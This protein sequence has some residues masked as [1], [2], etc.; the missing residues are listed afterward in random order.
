MQLVTVGCVGTVMPVWRS[1]VALVLGLARGPV[2]EAGRGI[3]NVL[4]VL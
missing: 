3:Y 4:R 1:V 2:G